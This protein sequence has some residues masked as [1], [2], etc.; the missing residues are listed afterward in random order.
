[1]PRWLD[2]GFSEAQAELLDQLVT[3]DDLRQELQHFTREMLLW[4]VGMLSPLYASMIYV[5]IKLG[6]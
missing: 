3:R 5:M 2:V 4:V 6:A 1:M